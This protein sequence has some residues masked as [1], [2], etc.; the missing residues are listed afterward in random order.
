MEAKRVKTKS[1]LELSLY[2]VAQKYIFFERVI[3]GEIELKCFM[4]MPL[5]TSLRIKGKVW[6][7]LQ[8]KYF[9]NYIRMI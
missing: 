3:S 9:K 1:F 8:C 4:H 7:M 2:L 6:I 5:P